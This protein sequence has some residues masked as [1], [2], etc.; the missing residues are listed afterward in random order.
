MPGM[1]LFRNRWLYVFGGTQFKMKSDIIQD[2]LNSATKLQEA[3]QI[4]NHQIKEEDEDELDN[5]K[6]MGSE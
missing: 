4:I 1:C 2:N 6:S 3:N 5:D